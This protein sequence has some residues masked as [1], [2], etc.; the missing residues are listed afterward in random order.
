MSLLQTYYIL[1]RGEAGGRH[2]TGTINSRAGNV[3]G[4]CELNEIA[5]LKNFFIWAHERSAAQHAAVRQSFGMPDPFRWRCR[6]ERSVALA[7]VVRAKSGRQ[8]VA[9]EIS[10]LSAGF[11]KLGDRAAFAAIVEDELLGLH[12]GNF[13]RYMV[14]PPDVQAWQELRANS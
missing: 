9:E 2:R 7:S 14:F 6:T 11:G 10:R 13:A 1:M 5:L 3:P 8:E 12:E 4:D